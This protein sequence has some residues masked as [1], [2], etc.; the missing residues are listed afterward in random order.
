LLLQRFS[1]TEGPAV[2]EWEWRPGKDRLNRRN[3]QG[4]SLAAGVSV[5]ADP[6]ASS[7]PDPYPYEATWQTVGSAGGIAVLFVVHTEPARQLDGRVVGR[8]IGVRKATP[9]ER[10]AYEEGTF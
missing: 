8:I 7:R 5:L 3:H 6:L 10:K 9:H 1:T 4:L 2:A